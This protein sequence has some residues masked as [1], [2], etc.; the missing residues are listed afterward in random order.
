VQWFKIAAQEMLLVSG[1]G[2]FSSTSELLFFFDYLLFPFL[3]VLPAGIISFSLSN[4]CWSSSCGRK[5][6]NNYSPAP[7][8]N[9]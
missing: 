8:S 2:H 3:L 5:I 4:I 6:S 7:D 1:A 9:L